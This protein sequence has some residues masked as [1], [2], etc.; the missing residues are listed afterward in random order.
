M[1]RMLAVIYA[2]G[3]FAAAPAPIKLEVTPRIGRAPQL[4]RVKV[5]IEPHERNRQ[6]CVAYD[7]PVYRSSCWLLEGSDAPKTHW[8]QFRDLPGGRYVVLGEVQRND[9]TL[10]TSRQELCVLGKPDEPDVACGMGSGAGS[11]GGIA[12]NP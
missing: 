11:G 2:L 5:S 1:R 6:A 7:G 4:I 12:E 10:H 9:G 8:L 3:M